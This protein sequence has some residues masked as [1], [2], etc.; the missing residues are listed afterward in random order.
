MAAFPRPLP[1]LR[2]RW[3]QFQIN[4]EVAIQVPE[5]TVF[6]VYFILACRT[7]GEPL[8]IDLQFYKL[9]QGLHASQERE[10]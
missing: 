9:G 3:C 2:P 6:T 1:A 10:P 8:S 4:M 7:R 5:C